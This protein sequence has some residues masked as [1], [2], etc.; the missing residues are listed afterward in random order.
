MRF[1]HLLLLGIL[2]YATSAAASAKSL[3]VVAGDNYEEFHTFRHYIDASIR[4][5]LEKDGWVVGEC[6]WDALTEETLSRF[7]AVIFIQTPDTFIKTEKDTRLDRM[8]TLLRDYLARGGGVLI[9]PDLFRGTVHKTVNAWLETYGIKALP[10]TVQETPRG[11]HPFE[12][13]PAMGVAFTCNL[14]KDTLTE[15]VSRFAY[16]EGNEL[17]TTFQAGNDWRVLVRG[18]K[19]AQSVPNEGVVES[20]PLFSEE[21][22]IVAVRETGRGRMAYWSGHSSFFILKPYH[23]YWDE[24]RILKEGD[25]LR[26]LKNLLVWLAASPDSRLGGFTN[27]AQTDI[28]HFEQAREKS[29]SQE[30][31]IPGSP[32]RGVIGLQSSLSGGPMSIADLCTHARKLGLDYV[33]FTEDAASMSS[34][35][36]W[37]DYVKACAEA[38]GSDFIAF[39]GVLVESPETLDRAVAFN[40]RKPWPETPWDVGD[41]QSFVRIGVNNAWRAFFALLDPDTAPVPLANQGAVNSLAV[42]SSSDESQGKSTAAGIFQR[43]QREMWGLAPIR[44]RNV[45]TEHDLSAAADTGT[46]WLYSEKWGSDFRVSQDEITFS[47]V[48]DGP[49]LKDFSA[50]GESTWKPPF[51]SRYRGRVEIDHLAP[52]QVVELWFGQNRRRAVTAQSDTV[53]FPFSFVA[54]G[55][56]HLFVR[57][58]NQERHTILQASALRFAK[59]RFN[60]FVGSDR[61]NGYWYPVREARPDTPGSIFIEGKYGV[62]GTSVYPQLAWGDHWQFRSENQNLSEPLGLE[63]GAPPGSVDRM[64]A[65]FY[66]KTAAGWESLAPWRGMSYFSSDAAVWT[67]SP[68]AERRE[69]KV[70]GRKE[71]SV[72]PSKLLDRKTDVTGFRWDDHAILWVSS[73]AIAKDASLPEARILALRL[74][75]SRNKFS[76]MSLLRASGEVEK[77]ELALGQRV[78]LRAGDGFSL[79]DMPMGMVSI[80][81]LQDLDGEVLADAD[82]AT[83]QLYPPAENWPPA[84]GSRATASYLV[85]IS[86][87]QSGQP[88]ELSSVREA[89]FSDNFWQADADREK[90]LVDVTSRFRQCV[91]MG[92]GVRGGWG[93]WINPG[94]S[95]RAEIRDFALGSGVG[96]LSR[97]DDGWAWRQIETAGDRGMVFVEKTPEGR[98]FIGQPVLC[99]VPGVQIE[100]GNL[101]PQGKAWNVSIHNP[102]DKPVSTKLLVHPELARIV[103]VDDP[104]CNVKP[105]ETLVRILE[106]KPEGL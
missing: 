104:V 22:P 68:I 100:L 91:S 14:A 12:A 60:S 1:L 65:G 36:V 101:D 40:L 20:A 76:T 75:D 84:V 35:D 10:Q 45:R 30:Q 23:P 21:P 69:S 103:K 26:L 16:P 39:P 93:T 99:D 92:G 70:A 105:G 28:F 41:F 25:D 5:N 86:R 7:Q 11:Q 62:I 88:R 55:S 72:E 89:V 24:G 102:T 13:Y 73:E 67:D 32:R 63:V 37:E 59:V 57:V 19:T 66:L 95:W 50:S 31:R 49:M 81:A 51:S 74:G 85:V 27:D 6:S 80:W 96:I 54:E 9:F 106:L 8:Q 98:A 17:T 18:E 97:A 3:L 58:V 94:R 90:P 29:I 82:R 79:G 78:R 56:G 4:E 47:A 71:I 87:H 15:G 48:A 42:E 43:T 44:Y 83:L 64:W 46:T 33:V 77:S 38:S 52:G 34:K 53:A 61:M 2:L